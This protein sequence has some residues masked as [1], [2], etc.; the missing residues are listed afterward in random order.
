MA[1]SAPPGQVITHGFPVLHAGSIPTDLNPQTWSLRIHG[2][3]EHPETIDFAG[4]LG[5]P[6]RDEIVDIHCVTSWSKIGTRWRGVPFRAVVERVAP[7]PSVG[8]VVFECEQGFTT[9]L[10]IGPLLD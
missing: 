4:L 6:Q 10:P 9:S 3:V 7:R 8:Y 5:M 1:G 2:D